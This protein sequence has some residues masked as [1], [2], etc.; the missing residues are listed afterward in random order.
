MRAAHDAVAYTV[1]PF[2]RDCRLLMEGGGTQPDKSDDSPCVKRS[3]FSTLSFIF[4]AP[5]LLWQMI[6]LHK[7]VALLHENEQG[8]RH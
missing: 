8:G 4:R 1:N 5:S 2:C 7:Q 3:F 6:V